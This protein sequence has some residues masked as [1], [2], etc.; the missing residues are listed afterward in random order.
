MK[1]DSGGT[2]SILTVRADN[3]IIAGDLRNEKSKKHVKALE[4]K[5]L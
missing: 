2:L 1:H 4:V 5:D 3:T